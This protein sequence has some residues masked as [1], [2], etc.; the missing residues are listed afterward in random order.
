MYYKKFL[1]L[2][3]V[4]CLLLLNVRAQS[5]AERDI[6]DILSAQQ[7]A[8]NRG[9][10]SAFMIG[11]WENDSLVFVG[12]NGPVYGYETTLKNYRKSYSD[13][14]RMGHFTSTI[15]R[16]NRLNRKYYLVLGQWHLDRSVGNIGGYYTLLFRK[17]NGHWVIVWDHSS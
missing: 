7:N 2:S 16:M 9:D 3:V 1:S 6:R 12:K 4:C 15:I 8:W 13:T 17:I 10:L 14:A 5:K 11:Y